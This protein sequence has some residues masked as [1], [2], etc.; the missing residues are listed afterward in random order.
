[1]LKRNGFKGGLVVLGTLALVGVGSCPVNAQT[2]GVQSLL[3]V[4]LY[5][6]YKT[7]LKKFGPPTE[8]RGGGEISAPN[9]VAKAQNSLA[10]GGG[11]TGG[12]GAGGGG[13]AGMMSGMM[14]GRMPQGMGGGAPG[15]PPANMM[16]GMMSGR[17]PAGV[18]GAPGGMP[19]GAG[20]LPGFGGG[21][22][23]GSMAA[24]GAGGDG[25]GAA[26]AGANQQA[27]VDLGEAFWWYTITK[28]DPKNRERRIIT[29]VGF[30]FNKS[31]KVIQIQEYGYAG[32]QPTNKGVSLGDALGRLLRVYGWSNNGE[33]LGG[34]QTFRYD[35][36]PKQALAFQLVKDQ[37]VGI[38]LG[39][40]TKPAPSPEAMQ[41]A[42][43]ATGEN[44]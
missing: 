35:A 27:Q 12:G 24:L 31:G 3:G 6:S 29:H 39:V 8:V 25:G 21:G 16:A 5:D 41:D 32:G 7:V 42:A 43:D 30:L 26:G 33:Q 19:S 38:T 13:M 20:G 28:I 22:K 17:M 4:R 40:S 1:M 18:G 10:G 14:A 15:G 23:M 2:K 37:V 9:T 34:V 36:G 11:M 44:Q